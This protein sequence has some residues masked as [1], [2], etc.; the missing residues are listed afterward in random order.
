M[1]IRYFLLV[2]LGLLYVKGFSQN[3][4]TVKGI[5][6]DRVSPVEFANVLFSD[7]E[8]FSNVVQFTLT[9]SIGAFVLDKI[10]FGEY[11]LQVRM[12]GYNAFTQK[13]VI[14]NEKVAQDIGNITLQSDA[15]LL[16]TITV[17][18][19]R[20]L[21]QKTTEG[22]I[23]NAASDITQVGGTA[24]DLLRNTPTVNV[25]AEGVIT[26]RGKTPL[27]LIN[28]RNSSFANTDQIAASDIESIEIITNPSAKYDASA[29]SGIINIRLK[30]NM[31]YGLSG[32]LTAGVGVGAKGR[33]NSGIMLN[34][35][36]GKW[37]TGL[38]YDNRYAGRVR[39]IENSR[40]NFD[41]P[42]EYQYNQERADKRLD[43]RHNLKFN[44]DFAPN[45]KN[46]FSFEAFGNITGQDNNESL[47]T[48]VL[49]QS[50]D[51]NS[52]NN[53]Y[54]EEIRRFNVV[55]F[56]YYSRPPH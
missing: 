32:A 37:N 39:N 44:A 50:N 22:F 27:I 23:L 2:V 6:T 12:L 28:G 41:L 47:N 24:T 51:F 7:K 25:D 45:E 10:P 19:Q 56:G 18:G 43:L 20:K 11:Y 16:S 1:K 40:T 31:E 9:D 29:E 8:D 36:S 26:L 48:T 3:T 55:E 42:D 52:K 33:V 15:T 53:R 54:S 17:T 14:S 13:I 21:I 30:K 38:D 35:K 49:N 34:Y 4:G 5:V 46:T